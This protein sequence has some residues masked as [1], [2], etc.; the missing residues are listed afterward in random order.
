MSDQDD[1]AIRIIV[2]NGEPEEWSYWEE[3]FLAKAS[4][5]G[6]AKVLTG[7]IKAPKDSEVLD[8]NNAANKEKIDIREQNK[9]AFEELI[10]S[11]DTS[12]DKGKIAFQIVKSCK[13]ADLKMG[14]AA[15]A[16][17]RLSEKYAPKIAPRKVELMKE[18]QKSS[19]KSSSEDPDV[20][21]TNLEGIR[22]KLQE[23]NFAISDEQFIIYVLNNLPAEYDIQISKLE[24]KLDDKSNPLTIEEV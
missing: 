24:S 23:M 6:F 11:I 5:K 14:D 8:P 18:F 1:R 10:L 16:W 12:K 19:L 21:L 9:L 22:T 2:F 15:L 3:K 7:I 17:R 20:W 4:K 13:T